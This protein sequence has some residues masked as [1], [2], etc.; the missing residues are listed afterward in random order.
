M[1]GR[2]SLPDNLPRLTNYTAALRC[3]NSTVPLCKGPDAGLVPLGSNRRYKRSQMLKVETKRGNAIICRYWRRNCIIFY[4]DGMTHIDIGSWHT[5]TTLMF[6]NDVYGGFTRYRGKIY[7]GKD[8]QFFHLNHAEGLWINPD[9]SPHEP[10]PEYAYDLDR[11]KWNEIRKR[12]KPFVDYAQDMVKVM[13][14]K[15][16]SDLVDEFRRLLAQYGHEYWSGLTTNIGQPNARMPHLTISPKEIRYDRGK[17]TET[18]REFVRRVETACN[19]KD[20][21]AMYP[22]MFVLQACASEQRWTSNGYVSECNPERVK[23][24]FYELLKFEYCHRIFNE[25]PQP[26]GELVADSNAKYFTTPRSK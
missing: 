15:A 14:P 12:L 5:P 26:M 25:T 2:N 10:P 23:K 7:Y 6:L 20:L 1:F 19:T 9:G 8:E 4:E 17:I 18:R 24:Y 13:E 16:G 11:T 22:L 3:Y 21:D